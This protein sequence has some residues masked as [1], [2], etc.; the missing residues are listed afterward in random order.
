MNKNNTFVWPI[1]PKP[2][3]NWKQI[4][5][6]I[7]TSLAAIYL[8][9]CSNIAKTP[10]IDYQDIDPSIKNT[11]TQ[12]KQETSNI[13]NLEVIEKQKESQLAFD[14]PKVKFEIN[15]EMISTWKA[16]LS[17]WEFVVKLNDK[18]I[19]E[20]SS[21][22]WLDN[23]SFKSYITNNELWSLYL[24]QLANNNYQLE[25]LKS[26]RQILEAAWDLMSYKWLLNE[27]TPKNI[28]S[29]ILFVYNLKK[30]MESNNQNYSLISEFNS[31]IFKD[32]FWEDL[33]QENLK[34]LYFK[35]KNI[36][37][38]WD[39]NDELFFIH[40]DFEYFVQNFESELYSHISKNNK[41]INPNQLAKLN[42]FDNQND[43]WMYLAWY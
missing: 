16:V 41:D 2:K 39:V 34:N 12:S 3:K 22:L 31:K 6:K 7:T 25:N 13:L 36:Q 20:V 1:K 28:D 27:Y 8:S 26:D 40:W 21:K 23:E 35:L 30:K 32:A 42:L 33:T 10:T 14:H 17:K 19:A 11:I 18:K 38:N 29:L 5:K 9:A 24:Y 37:K 43:N 15:D 4:W